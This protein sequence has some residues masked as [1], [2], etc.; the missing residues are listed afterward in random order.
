MAGAHGTA[1]TPTPWHDC[2]GG[3]TVHMKG[4]RMPLVWAVAWLQIV[5]LTYSSQ[6]AMLWA[7][8]STGDTGHR[9]C[10]FVATSLLLEVGQT[11]LLLAERCV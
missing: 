4:S 3:W 8:K 10:D 5:E 11:S 2:S 7:S 6:L 1:T 9:V